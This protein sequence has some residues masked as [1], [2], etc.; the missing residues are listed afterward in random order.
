MMQMMRWTSN[1]VVRAMVAA[2]LFALLLGIW[3][4]L[5]VPPSAF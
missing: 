5:W 2:I 4:Y 3:V 1:R